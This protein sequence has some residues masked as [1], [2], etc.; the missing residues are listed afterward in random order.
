YPGAPARY[1]V[2][3]RLPVKRPLGTDV[4]G[5][6]ERPDTCCDG[7]CCGAEQHL[8]LARDDD[9]V[10]RRELEQRAVAVGEPYAVHTLHRRGRA[11][12]TPHQRS[13]LQFARGVGETAG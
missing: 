9:P 1:P 2:A 5:A 7:G 6:P 11:L 3:V 4:A 8:E 10:P 13:N 12:F